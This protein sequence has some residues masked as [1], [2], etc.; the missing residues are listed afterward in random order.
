MGVALSLLGPSVSYLEDRLNV[1]TGVIGIL[2]A[3]VAIGNFV[4]ALLGG[5]WITRWTGHQVLHVGIVSFAVGTMLLA[6]SE[7]FIV[8]CLA[9]ALI[10]A[11]TG[12]A[13]T[14]MNTM[15][16]WARS[17]RSGP[18]LNALHLMFGV[19]ALFAP[20]IV[21][22]SL[23]WTD[24]LWLAVVVVTALAI[25]AA[26]IVGRREA[27]QHPV[28]TDDVFRPQLPRRTVLVV[29]VFF[30]LYIGGEVGFG[31]WIFTYAEE[32]GMAGSLPALVT[33]AF[34]GAFCL[35]RLVA[36]PVSGRVRPLLVVFS[37]CALSVVALAVMIVGSGDVWT[38]WFGAAVF[39]FAAG[40]QYPTMLAMVDDKLS[41]SASATSWI[42]GAAA[43]G[44]LIVPT[45]IGPLIDSRGSDSMPVVVLI[46]CALSLLWV[47]VVQR[48][49]NRAHALHRTDVIHQQ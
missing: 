12:M 21:D 8:A 32:I 38:V 48:S 33:A 4:G 16:V 15:V 2:F 45:S 11:A 24:S 40:P 7:K 23:A 36:I 25:T 27:P 41:L 39:G 49:I 47:L 30:M 29:S 43:V 22:R 18:A 3:L 20:L 5:R 6:L 19:G 14:A 46:V 44:G 42:V 34:W 1:S 13:D 10:G 37:A 17:G 9:V 31:G 26:C 28:H 35:G